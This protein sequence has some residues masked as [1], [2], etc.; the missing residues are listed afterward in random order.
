MLCKTA[1][2]AIPGEPVVVLDS[3]DACAILQPDCF[4]CL[5]PGAVL[6][7]IEPNYAKVTPSERESLKATGG[8]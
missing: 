3:Q 6:S 4:D 8:S 1:V 2:C 7:V 5:C